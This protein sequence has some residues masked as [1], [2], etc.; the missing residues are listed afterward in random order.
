MSTN[1]NNIIRIPRLLNDYI[2]YDNVQ[3]NSIV[4]VTSDGSYKEIIADRGLLVKDA[5][6][7]PTFKSYTGILYYSNSQLTSSDELTANNIL[8][9]NSVNRLDQITTSVNE[10]NNEI[11][12]GVLT[13][14]KFNDKEI[15]QNNTIPKFS[16]QF[17]LNNAEVTDG[18]QRIEYPYL[19]Y[20]KGINNGGLSFINAFD[21]TYNFISVDNTNGVIQMSN[22]NEMM[23]SII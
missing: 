10:N 1:V 13:T 23:F 17:V 5:D 8:F 2:V 9:V 11:N 14:Y 18:N 3:N 21:D 15:I 6:E 12:G 20:G 16:S 4:Y 19:I 22:I 7:S